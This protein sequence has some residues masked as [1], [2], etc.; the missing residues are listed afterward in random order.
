MFDEK[1]PNGKIR[2]VLYRNGIGCDNNQLISD[3][4]ELLEEQYKEGIGDGYYLGQAEPPSNVRDAIHQ[5]NA[6]Q[7]N[8]FNRANSIAEDTKE[9]DWCL[10]G[11]L[12]DNI[13]FELGRITKNDHVSSEVV[14]GKK[15][16][17][18]RKAMWPIS[19]ST[20]NGRYL[21]LFSI[22]KMLAVAQKEAGKERK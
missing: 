3:L 16:I 22:N 2:Y 12:D 20:I 5:I 6:A 15:R 10:I 18:F 14:Q 8:I 21:E 1:T 9:L 7:K 11:R 13:P 4:L 17:V 19:I